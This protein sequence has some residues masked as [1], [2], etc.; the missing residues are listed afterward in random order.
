[1]WEWIKNL[2]KTDDEQL[3]E[4]MFVLSADEQCIPKVKQVIQ[5]YGGLPPLLPPTE[6]RRYD[7]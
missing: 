2:G 5:Y 3:S 6:D 7:N 1:M 4:H